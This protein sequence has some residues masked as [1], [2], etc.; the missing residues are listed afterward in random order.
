MAARSVPLMGFHSGH[1]TRVGGDPAA[2]GSPRPGRA[3][4][5]G[6]PARGSGEPV[7]ESTARCGRLGVHPALAPEEVAFLAGFGAHP[8]PGHGQGMAGEGA[9]EGAGSGRVARL[10]PGQPAIACPWVPCAR[11]CCLVLAGRQRPGSAAA[12]LRFLLAEFLAPG[13][14]VTGSVVAAGVVSRWRVLL[15]ADGADVFE[16]DLGA[17][18]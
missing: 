7:A 3:R 18:A 4:A 10:W 11:G 12:W 8:V 5:W 9:G 6:G 14:A 13:H 15:I 2:E 17:G 16:G 1:T